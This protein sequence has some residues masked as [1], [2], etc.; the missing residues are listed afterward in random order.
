MSL[1]QCSRCGVQENTACTFGYHA[2][3]LDPASLTAKGFDPNGKY[4]SACYEGKWHGIFPQE[5]YPLGSM[6]TDR[7]GNLVQKDAE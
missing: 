5:F 1:F 4:C 6:V 7:D 3:L 2:R